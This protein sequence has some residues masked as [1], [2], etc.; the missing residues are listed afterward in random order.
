MSHDR[1][2]DGGM[3]NLGNAIDGRKGRE[4][5]VVSAAI[6]NKGLEW[7]AYACWDEPGECVRPSIQQYTCVLEMKCGGSMYADYSLFAL[8]MPARLNLASSR[9]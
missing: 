6:Y 4:I 8:M 7:Y 2:V 9:A 3:V 5:A 1:N